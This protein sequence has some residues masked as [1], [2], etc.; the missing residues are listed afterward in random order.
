MMIEFEMDELG[1][2]IKLLLAAQKKSISALAEFTGIS[3][4][5]IYRILEGKSDIKLKD[6]IKIASFLQISL[7][8]LFGLEES[9]ERKDF[10]PEYYGLTPGKEAIALQKIYKKLAQKELAKILRHAAKLLEEE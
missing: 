2:R 4:P 9:A 5:T 3:R 8:E 7:E 10:R 6:A 1:E